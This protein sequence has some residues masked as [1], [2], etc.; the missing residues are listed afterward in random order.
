MTSKNELSDKII[1]S[2]ARPTN[3]SDDSM[4]NLTL[5]DDGMN[6]KIIPGN[7]TRGDLSQLEVKEECVDNHVEK[8]SDP[9]GHIWT[10]TDV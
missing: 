8:I 3:L 5:T 4:N 9:A 1:P 10:V 7:S 2:G 6:E